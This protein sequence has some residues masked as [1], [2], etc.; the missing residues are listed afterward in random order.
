[1][2]IYNNLSTLDTNHNFQIH[3]RRSVDLCECIYY[4]FL[5]LSAIAIAEW[6]QD[7]QQDPSAPWRW[8]WEMSLGV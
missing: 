7:A 1:M 6:P 4:V 2:S 8:A 5:S 3:I